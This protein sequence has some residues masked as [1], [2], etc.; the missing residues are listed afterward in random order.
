MLKFKTYHVIIAKHIIDVFVTFMAGRHHRSRRCSYT[1]NYNEGY[2]HDAEEKAALIKQ[3]FS[4][5][6]DI[7]DSDSD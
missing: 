2:K 3:K 5:I 4:R 6:R 7:I 1:E